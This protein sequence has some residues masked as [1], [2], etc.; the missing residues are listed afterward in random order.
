MSG[1][2]RDE[3]VVLRTYKLGEADRIVVLATAEHGK[4]R[5]VAKGVRKTKSRFGARLEP[6]SHVALQLYEG[7]NLDTITQAESIDSFR[8]I[9]EDLDRYGSAMG[10]LEVIDQIAMEGEVDPRRFS[11]LV[12]VLRTLAANDN[13]LVVPAFY[14]KVLAHE[15]FQPEVDACVQ[16]GTADPLVAIDLFAGGMLCQACRQGRAVSGEALRL[17]RA[18]LGGGLNVVLAEEP[19]PAVSE[20][21]AIATEAVEHHLERR[22]RTPGLLDRTL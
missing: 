15:G 19:S 7:R 5:A 3:G 18:V 22:L 21:S 17:L 4:V 11:M 6:L 1:L 10:V 2:Y 16:C 14:L 13:P 20:V 8:A 12:G 9:R